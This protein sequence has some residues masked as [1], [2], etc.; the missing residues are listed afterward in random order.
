MRLTR[1]HRVWL[2]L[3]CTIAVAFAAIQLPPFSQPQA[4]H[5]FAD[6]RTWLGVPN[7][8]N[9]VSNLA[10]LIVSALGLAIVLRFDPHAFITRVERLPY[11]LFFLAL[12]ATSFGSVWYH[13][14]PDNTSLFWDRLPLI[15]CFATLLSAVIAERYSLKI[16]IWLLPPL[17]A[18]AVATVFYWRW[19]EAVGGGNVLPYLAFQI[20]VILAILLLMRLFPPRYTRSAD[21]FNAVTLYGL[22]FAAELLDHS[23]YAMGQ[24]LSGH[25]LKHLLAA[26]AMYQLVRMLR[27]RMGVRLD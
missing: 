10:F 25:T 22:A 24:I 14:A 16:G 20:Y 7:F 23:I 15:V 8:L 21:L 13:L 12:A 1:R 3:L 4:Y 26:G 27:A 19:S 6:A 9:V 18:T 5:R 11:A 17:V 2:L